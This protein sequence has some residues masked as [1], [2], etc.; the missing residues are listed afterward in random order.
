MCACV[1]ACPGTCVFACVCPSSVCVCARVCAC[2]RALCLGCLG[3]PN[4]VCVSSYVSVGCTGQIPLGMFSY[5]GARAGQGVKG[6]VSEWLRPV[7]T[8]HPGHW[9]ESGLSMC[10]PAC[11]P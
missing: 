11:T 4:T 10:T 1:C 7:P 6:E 8:L 9:T 2:A 5:W 3:M